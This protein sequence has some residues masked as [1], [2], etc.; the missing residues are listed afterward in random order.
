MTSD[1]R[2]QVVAQMKAELGN[3]PLVPP[4]VRCRLGFHKNVEIPEL[5]AGLS[6]MLRTFAVR[7][8]CG[9]VRCGQITCVKLNNPIGGGGS[10]RSGYTNPALL[11]A[12]AAGA[13]S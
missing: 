2:E 6:R 1:E 13:T 5:R 12:Y 4:P 11:R 3:D 10:H 9:C 8:F 7:S